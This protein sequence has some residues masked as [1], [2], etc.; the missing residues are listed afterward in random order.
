MRTTRRTILKGVGGA[1]ALPFLESIPGKAHA[2]NKTPTRFLVVGNPFGA[3]PDYFF[4]KDF[5]KNFTISPT[6]K[7]LDWLSDRLTVVSHTDHGMV[8]GHGREI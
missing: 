1:L 3:H 5:G 4:P 6:L 8:S 2:A 7:S